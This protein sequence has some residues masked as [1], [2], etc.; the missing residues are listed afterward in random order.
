M[1]DIATGQAVGALRLAAV[2]L[3]KSYGALLAN[4]GIDFVARRGS[5]HAIVGG[6][7]A[8]KSTLVKMLQ[9]QQSPDAG[10]VLVDGRKTEFR[11]PRDAIRA[12]I[13]MVHQ[14]FTLIPGLSLLE[15]LILGAEPRG[16]FGAIDKAT[17]LSRAK[18]LAQDAGVRID[19][20]MKEEDAPVHMRQAVE[21]LRLIWRGADVLILD[22]P[23]AVLAPPQI[24]DLLAL[25]RNLRDHG[26][27][28][29]F[30]SHKLDE[31]LAVAD[32]ITVLRSGRVMAARP[33]SGFDKAAL[34]G[35]L[36]GE[37]VVEPVVEP[38]SRAATPGE[39]VLVL[40]DVS[41]TREGMKALDDFSL[42]LRAGEITGIAGVAGNGQDELAGLISG[43]LRPTGGEILLCGT[44]VTALDMRVRRGLGLA[45]LSPDRRKEGLCL[46]AAISDNLLASHQRKPTFSR[47][48]FLKRHA[49]AK[50]AAAQIAAFDICCVSAAQQV[51]ALSGGNQQKVAMARELYDRPRALLACQ[52][53]RGVDIRG[54]AAIH[55]ELLSFR[56]AGGAVLL[57]SEE[58]EELIWLSDRIVTICGGKTT[59]VYRRGD[60][61]VD[62][63]GRAM[64]GEV[65]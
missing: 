8:G 59:G 3:T 26:N 5:V 12:G 61:G 31:V 53:T 46:E 4:D 24:R 39:P 7:G 32:D 22:E 20:S 50:F 18:A 64:L 41:L 10:S 60:A 52:P 25:M 2:G 48:G 1:S 21:I 54:I 6:N 40:R 36:I 63:I 43:F 35:L 30:I 17:A 28:I 42:T 58:L 14:E 16:R 49:V 19:W 15:N 62:L 55:Q 47:Q 45:Y 29:L 38:A 9:G 13:G 65:A 56:D 37:P 34:A 27:T 33:T 57:I 44:D 23:T 51:K 11:S